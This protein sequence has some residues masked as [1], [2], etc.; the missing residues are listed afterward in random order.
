MKV[1][2]VIP[3]YNEQSIIDSAID[4]FYSFMKS[5]YE[6]FE[7]IF[8]SDG[9]TDGCDN[10][11]MLA[12]KQ[13]DR[14]K[15]C[16]YMPNRGKG[17][18]VRTGIMLAEGDVI[19]FTDCDNAYGTDAVGRM[20]D[21]LK[22]SDNDV[23][24]G[25][26][27]LSSDGYEGYTFIRK[28]ASKVYIKSIAIAAGFKLS[29]SQC[30]IKGFKKE[31]AKKIF[32]NTEVDRWAFDLEAIMIANKLSLKIGEMPVKIINHRESKIHVLSDSV[33]MLKDVNKMKKRINKAQLK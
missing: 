19:V 25:S 11:V 29:D 23:I 28:L 1:S 24:V 18:A 12:S 15:L 27:N 13:D 17:Y 3:M 4:T 16:S 20:F 33:K 5:K 10:A 7:L 31:A 21:M 9:S 26:R 6:D 30:G 8:V 2:L 32:R 14:I 22:N